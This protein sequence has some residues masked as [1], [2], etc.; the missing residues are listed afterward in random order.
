MKKLYLIL[1]SGLFAFSTFSQQSSQSAGSPMLYLSDGMYFTDA[2]QI[3]LYTGDYRELHDNGTIR[4][5]MQIKN[6]VPEGAYM[7]YFENRKP[8]EVRSY[9]EGKLHG[10][11]RTYDISGQLISEAE[12]KMGRKHGT[13]RIW[14]ELGAQRYEMNYYEGNKTGIWRMWDE[15]GNMVDEKRY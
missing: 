7:V 8:K 9:K 1:L 6:G 11:W 4:L 2:T 3:N 14:D 5:E 13:W 15:K 10:L 12:Y